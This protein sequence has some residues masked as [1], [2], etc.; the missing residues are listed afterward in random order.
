MNWNRWIGRAFWLVGLGFVAFGLAGMAL[1]I[2][3]AIFDPYDVFASTSVFTSW[4][5]WS[6]V[7][8]G[9]LGVGW[10]VIGLGRRWLAR[11]E[12][13][14]DWIDRAY[15]PLSR[16]GLMKRL[17]GALA[18]FVVLGVA[19]IIAFGNFY[20]RRW[21]R[22]QS[23]FSGFE[24]IHGQGYWDAGFTGVL[25]GHL[26]SEDVAEFVKMNQLV[27][28]PDASNLN[29]MS[30]V[31]QIRW[32]EKHWPDDPEWYSR[33]IPRPPGTCHYGCYSLCL[34]DARSGRVWIVLESPD[35]AGD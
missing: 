18:A 17:L 2:L 11:T 27:P 28:D 23:Q 10:V 5:M 35:F 25:T 26:G 30:A 22:E 31:P 16:P 29:H 13:K 33:R 14:P 12:G 21:V 32:G 34:L 9:L 6:L 8:V 19:G 15:A 3:F 20:D 1:C 24:M 7:P 4:F